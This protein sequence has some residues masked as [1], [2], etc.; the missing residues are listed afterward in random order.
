MFKSAL[1]NVTVYKF[2]YC[3]VDANCKVNHN[4]VIDLKFSPNTV[5]AK[6][7]VGKSG[8]ILD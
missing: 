5:R 1:N 3:D 7:S 2:F 8:Q 4:G 6:N